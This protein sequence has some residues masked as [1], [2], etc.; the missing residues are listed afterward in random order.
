MRHY[1]KDNFRLT[2]S[3]GYQLVKA[4][5]V[6][7]T[8]MDAAL[9]DLDISSQQ[10]GIMLMLR[11]KLASTPFELSKMLGID[12]GL[13]TRML[14]KLEA[15]GLVVRSRDD[16]DRRVVN[17]ALTKAGIAVAD[18]IPEIAPDVLNA[19]LKDFT[20][21]ELTELRRLLRKFVSD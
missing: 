14:D 11:Q 20:K 1:T 8:E 7:V 16:Q 12:T 15:K 4:R 3:V 17:L 21:A 19:R 6:I 13:M 18:E 2:E 9:K 5:N 10:M